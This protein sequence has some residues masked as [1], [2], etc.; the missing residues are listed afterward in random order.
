MSQR[1]HIGKTDKTLYDCIIADADGAELKIKEDFLCLQPNGYFLGP[2]KIRIS[3]VALYRE[4]EPI[5]TQVFSSIGNEFPKCTWVF[6]HGD[7]DIVHP[8]REELDAW[9]EQITQTP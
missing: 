4:I 2:W 7:K 6:Y 3:D 8:T 5:L 9:L 1:L